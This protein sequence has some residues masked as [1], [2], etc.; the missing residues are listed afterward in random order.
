MTQLFKVII[1]LTILLTTSRYI[2]AYG[3][4]VYAI[5]VPIVAMFSTLAIFYHI[6]VR[7]KLNSIKYQINAF[8]NFLIR[9]RRLPYFFTTVICILVAMYLPVKLYLMNYIEIFATIIS[10]AISIFI[11]LKI[12]K[13]TYNNEYATFGSGVLLKF[14][15]IILSSLIY[16]L[17]MHAISSDI[18]IRALTLDSE[19]IT[20]LKNNPI[21]YN[22]A[23]MIM[24]ADS[25]SNALLYSAKGSSIAKYIIGVIFFNGLLFYGLINLVNTSIL[26]KES[27]TK[28]VAPY[29]SENTGNYKYLPALFLTILLTFFYPTLFS[30]LEL[31]AKDHMRNINMVADNFIN[32]IND[33]SNKTSAPTE[34]K[35]DGVSLDIYK[36]IDRYIDWNRDGE[37][38]VKHSLIII[39]YVTGNVQDTFTTSRD[40]ARI[41][42]KKL[43]DNMKDFFDGED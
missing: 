15:T 28:A 12:N 3:S 14:I 31:Q 8:T 38:D 17:L 30:K 33:K 4:L 41:T 25:T 23:N 19:K 32:L 11:S 24:L 1:P 27:L 5:L 13:L 40:K 34:L 26:N 39:D 36:K 22:I 43:I 37:I 6:T 21:A 35:L 16:P 10:L 29:N 9:N 18:D 7:K 20:S 42:S 2:N